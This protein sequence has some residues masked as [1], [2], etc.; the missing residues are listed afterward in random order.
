MPHL[1]LE[2]SANL[3]E[4]TRLV[5]LFKKCHILL[6]EYLPTDMNSCV[7][8]AIECDQYYIGEGQPNRAFI[9][10]SLKVKAGR[11]FETLQKTSEALLT[12]I[13]EYCVESHRQ[14]NLKISLDVVELQNNYFSVSAAKVL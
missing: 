7:S 9:H 2:H 8:R 13:S 14:L 1:S 10:V 6:A 11:T 3:L 12:A 5:D 4:K